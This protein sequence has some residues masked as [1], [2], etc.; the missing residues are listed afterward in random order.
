METD[1][2]RIGVGNVKFPSVKESKVTPP[3]FYFSF[4]SEEV[5]FDSTE[6]TFDQ[7]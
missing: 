2:Q 4:D 6:N 7:Q 5:T 3:K 1:I